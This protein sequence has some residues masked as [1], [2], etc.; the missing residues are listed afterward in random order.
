MN[1]CQGHIIFTGGSRVHIQV[2]LTP[3]PIPFASHCN[4]LQSLKE[5]N[6]SV[7]RKGQDVNGF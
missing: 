6:V 2:C 4:L 1:L 5:S 3:K 7:K